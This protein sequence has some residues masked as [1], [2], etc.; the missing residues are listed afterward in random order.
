MTEEDARRVADFWA[1][2]SCG[3]TPAETEKGRLARDN[4]K[5]RA[6]NAALQ[7]QLAGAKAELERVR[8]EREGLAKF[9]ER[10][11]D[12]VQAISDSSLS[13]ASELEEAIALARAGGRGK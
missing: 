12:H 8:G 10:A 3:L 4:I 9:V 6:A 13:M 11:R 7:E 5:L 2:V 1:D